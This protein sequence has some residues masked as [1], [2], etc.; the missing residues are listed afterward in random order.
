MVFN[1]RTKTKFGIYAT[2]LLLGVIVLFPTAWVLFGSLKPTNELFAFPATFIP[3]EF[4]L[5][6]YVTVFRRTPMSLY[7]KNTFFVAIITVI[8][9]L[10]LAAPASYGFSRYEFRL[11]YPLLIGM[12]GLQ[13][14]PSTVNI[15]PYY[16]MLSR[17]NLLNSLTGLILIYISGRIPF[18]IWILKGFFDSLPESL[19]DA[20]KVDGCSPTRTFWS[21]MLPLSLP[22]LGAAGFL[23][24]LAAWGEL[25]I[26]LIVASSRDV[27]VVSVGLYTFFGEDVT[28]YNQLFAATIVAVLPI[29]AMFFLSQETFVSGLT[30]GS[31]K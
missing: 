31:G 24:F 22:G 7:L 17:L 1:I 13:L 29:L 19:I 25:L 2:Y 6:N 16:V 5:E 28:A 12:L 8:G 30:R 18:S 21:I 11:K 14:I 23:S 20:A 9:S 10:L 27:A 15:I 26:P 3:R 4:T